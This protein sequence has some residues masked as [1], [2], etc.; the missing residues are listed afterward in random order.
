MT[1]WPVAAALLLLAGACADH[2]PTK[3]AIPVAVPKDRADIVAVCFSP[4]D[5]TREAVEAV[6][7]ELCPAGS[8]GVTAWK[9]DRYLN[10]CP[11]MKKSRASF[12]CVPGVK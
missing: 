4:R 11:V 7:L 9:V 12:L 10:D 1:R 3:T 5:H 2:P 6:A 8:V